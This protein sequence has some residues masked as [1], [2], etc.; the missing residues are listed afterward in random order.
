MSLEREVAR[1]EELDRRTGNV[2]SERLGSLGQEEGI[3]LS[4][5]CKEAWLVRAEII[6][7]SWVERD[8]ALVVAE[9]IQLDFVGAGSGQIE[10]VERI[11]VWRNRG[12]VRHTVRVLPA[13][14]VRREETAERFAVG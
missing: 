7:E 11:A 5:C 12:R 2:A 14:R 9:Q 10:I 8:V 3:V 6:L 1:V 4:P 13:R